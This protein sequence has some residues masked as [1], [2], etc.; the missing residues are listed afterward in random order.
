MGGDDTH[1]FGHQVIYHQGDDGV[2]GAFVIHFPDFTRF[3]PL[4]QQFRQPAV[5]VFEDGVDLIPR[6]KFPDFTL[7]EEDFEDVQIVSEDLG[8]VAVDLFQYSFQRDAVKIVLQTA[9]VDFL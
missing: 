2:G 4:F 9:L 1:Q 3:R 6:D 8:E 7:P 5:P